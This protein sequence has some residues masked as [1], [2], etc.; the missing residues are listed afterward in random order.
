MLPDGRVAVVGGMHDSPPSVTA[1]VEIYDPNS[2]LWSKGVS[3]S[4]ARVDQAAALLANGDI[5]V[6]GGATLHG[7]APVRQVETFSL[8]A[9]TV[10]SIS[11]IS[12]SQ[13]NTILVIVI[14]ALAVVLAA[15]MFSRMARAI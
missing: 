8:N 12:A 1:S 9:T 15:A 7:T 13:V 11:W 2:G 5:L 14:L 10:A 3:M 4:T 6:T